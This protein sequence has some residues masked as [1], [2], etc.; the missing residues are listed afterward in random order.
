MFLCLIDD[1]A[2]GPFKIL[3]SS[4]FNVEVIMLVKIWIHKCRSSYLTKVLAIL[5]ACTSVPCLRAETIG[6]LA[7]NTANHKS[8]FEL[9]VSGPYGESMMGFP[10]GVTVGYTNNRAQKLG[11]YKL[12]FGFGGF[13]NQGSAWDFGDRMVFI[14]LLLASESAHGLRPGARVRAGW[15]IQNVYLG[16][17]LEGIPGPGSRSS[18]G[19]QL[20]CFF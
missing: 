15:G 20:G 3:H 11:E 1:G 19:L 7:L 2:V 17:Y 13:Y 6:A 8:G 5:L 4:L 12:Y 14:E 16:Y 9:T 10:V 18:V